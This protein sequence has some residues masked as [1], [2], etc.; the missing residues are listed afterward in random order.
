MH[1]CNESALILRAF[2]NRLRAGTPCKQN[3]AVEQDKNIKWSKSPRI[4]PAGK[5]KKRFTE[6]ISEKPSLK[7]RMKD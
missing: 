1:H 7:F 3:P 4:S 6:E 5:K 2:E